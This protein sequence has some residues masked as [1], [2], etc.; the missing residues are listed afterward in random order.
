[1][2]HTKFKLRGKLI[3]VLRRVPDEVTAASIPGLIAVVADAREF[4]QE[5]VDSPLDYVSKGTIQEYHEVSTLLV[6]CTSLL[7]D[8]MQAALTAFRAGKES[9]PLSAELRNLRDE[10]LRT[11]G[12]KSTVSMILAET[13]ADR[14]TDLP[15]EAD[16]GKE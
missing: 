8:L 12:G 10:L 16:S 6:K 2:T 7:A 9:F 11:T 1:M 4:Y 3:S 5:L 14:M 13:V 15:G